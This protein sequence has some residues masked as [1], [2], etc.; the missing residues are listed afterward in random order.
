MIGKISILFISIIILFFLAS[1]VK[2]KNYRN[3]CVSI[4]ILGTFVGITFSLYHF[5]A[6]NISGSIPIFIN[7][8]KMA[9]ITSATGIS[10]SII[11]SLK[12]PDSEVSSLETLIELQKT[13]NHILEASLANLAESS[14]EEIIK[15]LKEV[16]GDFNSNIENQFGDNFKALNEAFNKLVIWQENYTLMIENQQV[17]TQKQHEL[18]MKRLADF[19]VVGNM[20]IDSLQKQ[21]ESLIQLFNSHTTELKRQT[22]GVHAITS[23]LMTHSREIT[24]N[25]NLS[26]N[27]V[28]KQIKDSVKIAEDNLIAL[29]G[30]ANGQLRS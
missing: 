22:E 7:G 30:V 1:L 9:F 17:A 27:N 28:N 12:K 19:E 3:E 20:R 23:T 6:G 15:A 29:I 4:G 13:N 2:N 26:V 11:L 8:L 16:V 25:L 5:D 24:N 18:S 10:A 14:S 21:S